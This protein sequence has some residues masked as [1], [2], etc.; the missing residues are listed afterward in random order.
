MRNTAIKK[1]MPASLFVER[2][3][4]VITVLGLA[5]LC[6]GLL[7]HLVGRFSDDLFVAQVGAYILLFGITL[8]TIRIL[9]W[10]AEE[11]VERSL[12]S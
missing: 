6:V 9:S 11:I 10:I 4:S 1:Q 8:I 5:C 12:E 7:L 3:L 2:L